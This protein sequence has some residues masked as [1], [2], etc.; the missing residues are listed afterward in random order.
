[1][2]RTPNMPIC[3]GCG[4]PIE[5][6]DIG[7]PYRDAFDN[8]VDRRPIAIN[9]GICTVTY[10]C[11]GAQWSEAMSVDDANALARRILPTP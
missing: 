11:H 8:E 2:H 1:M 3:G 5:Q 4:K 7:S 9:T 6:I 10:R